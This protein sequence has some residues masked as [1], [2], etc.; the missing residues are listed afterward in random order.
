MCIRDSFKGLSLGLA[1]DV[2]NAAAF[3]FVV[4]ILPVPCRIQKLAAGICGSEVLCFYFTDYHYVLQFG[5]HI[6][7]STVEYLLEPR[8]FSSTLADS[9]LKPSLFFVVLLPFALLS[10]D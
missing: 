6:P 5:T 2:M 3:A 10:L 1:Y 7:F 4:A 8:H 9:L